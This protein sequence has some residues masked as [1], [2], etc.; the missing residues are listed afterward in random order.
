[1]IDLIENP[2]AAW[3][4]CEAV[5]KGRGAPLPLYHRVAWGHALARS[6][7]ACSLLAIR[8]GGEYVG[9]FAFENA[10]SRS[11]PGHRIFSIQRLGIGAG[12]V[13][14]AGLREALAELCR[15]ARV[16]WRVL[17]VTVD[18]FSLD[19][20][21]RRRTANAL[22]ESGFKKVPST[23][24]YERT[25]V[26]DLAPTEETLFAGIHKNARQGVRN[27]ARFP[28]RVSLATSQTLSSRLQHLSD[29]TRGRTGGE[30][31]SLDWD[32][33][34]ELSAARPDL[35]R[36]AILER[37]DSS[38]PESVLAF[39]WGCMHGEVGEYSESGSSRS[40]DL[41]VSTSYSLLWD[42]ILWSK[43]EG[44]KWFDLGGITSGGTHS[45]DPLG[46]IS[47]FKRRFSQ[48]ELEVGEQWE[49]EPRP[50]RARMAHVVSAGASA[51]RSGID[52]FLR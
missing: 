36:I 40:T 47:D 33:I 4:K 19:P 25:L 8:H 11:L 34:I 28:V 48:R 42:L 18:V 12:G 46:G 24:S 41:K 32:S 39:A 16:K 45:D 31:R 49:L 9:A 29:E 37:T 13:D 27:I 17:R 5:L 7:V 23:R 3:E 35:S 50:V 21:S 6:G 14:D 44:A 2:N 22:R 43:R 26:M 15:L 30:R 51:I 1:M 38:G 20:E 10:R 52:R